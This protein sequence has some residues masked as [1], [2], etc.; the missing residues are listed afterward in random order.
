MSELLD[1]DEI[2]EVVAPEP[3]LTDKG[4]NC[5][6]GTRLPRASHFDNEFAYK[7]TM[8]EYQKRS[9]LVKLC[10][11]TYPAVDAHMVE[12]LVDQHLQHPETLVE[13]MESDEVFMRKFKK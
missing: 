8:E 6:D 13:K 7:Y 2:L 3:V 10:M 9:A 12:I 11:E 1:C 5:P 4:L